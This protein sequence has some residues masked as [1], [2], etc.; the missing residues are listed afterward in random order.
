MVYRT[1]YP[2]SFDFHAT[3]RPVYAGLYT[4]HVHQGSMVNSKLLLHIT[5]LCAHHITYLCAHHITYLCAQHITYLCAHHITYLC[6]HHITYLCAHHI[7]YLCAHHI[8]YLC[9]HHI[10]YLCAHHI[11]YLCAHHITYLCAVA[12]L[13][14][15]SGEVCM[16]VG[17]DGVTAASAL[18]NCS[19]NHS[20]LHF[21]VT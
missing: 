11:T 13:V 17:H 21:S 14:H 20:K 8:T 10:T 5:Y 6:A 4:A 15:A 12:E 19:T 2:Y 18:S 7:T 1:F 3:C 9:A 16:D